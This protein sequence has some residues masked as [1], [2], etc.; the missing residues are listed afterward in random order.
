MNGYGLI[1]FGTIGRRVVERLAR[2]P[3]A[4]LLVATLTRSTS[5]SEFIAKKPA[6]AI[7]CASRAWLASPH[8]REL[9]TTGRMGAFTP[10]D[11]LGEIFARFCIGK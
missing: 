3:D 9:P 8:A 11:L 2:S 4:P 5:L 7:E 6:I 1:G 10:D